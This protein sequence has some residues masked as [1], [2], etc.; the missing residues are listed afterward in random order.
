MNISRK[1]FGTT[2]TGTQV[3]CICIS[4]SSGYEAEVLTYGAYLRSFKAPDRNGDIREITRNFTTL[5]P[6][7]EP[8]NYC[9][10]TIGRYANRI[11]GNAFFIDGTEYRLES[12]SDICQLHGGPRGFNTRIWEAFPMLEDG[13]ASVKLTLTSEDGDQGF[14]GT[15]DVALTVTLTEKNELFFLYEAVTDSPTYIS[16]TNH[17]YWNLRGEVVEG[18]IY[19][20]RIR[21][22]AES[23]VAVD[24]QLLP[25]GVLQSVAGTVFDLR[26]SVPIGRNIAEPNGGLGYD[27]NFVLPAAEGRIR[28]AA[29]VYDPVS[30][31]AMQVLTNAPALQFY[32]DNFSTPKHASYCLEAGELPDA[33][34]HDSFPSP[35]LDPGERYRQVT[36]HTFTVR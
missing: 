27:N 4:N 22:N 19:D 12:C 28:D 30:G 26:K 13:R 36:I 6:Y 23:T 25:T 20:Q 16:L 9:G 35:R 34:H 10:A 14:P 29:D 33:M 24:G 1:P 8:D 7:L 15:V 17:T 3:D 2:V 11:A 18:N 32:S 21:I 31:R 5:S